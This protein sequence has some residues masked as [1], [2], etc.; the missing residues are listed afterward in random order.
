M[1]VS[2]ALSSCGEDPEKARK[3]YEA[4]LF[5]GKKKEHVKALKEFKKASKYDPSR[6]EY[7]FNVA[8]SSTYIDSSSEEALDIYESIIDSVAEIKDERRKVSLESGSY[9]G[10]ASI[11][12]VREDKEKAIFYLKKTILSASSLEVIHNF[13]SGDPDFYVF[14]E[15]PEFKR[16]LEWVS[17]KNHNH[18]KTAEIKNIVREELK[19]MDN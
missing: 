17:I 1:L 2:F 3:H 6:L 14:K 5:Y 18:I 16:I 10:I 15:E 9:Y 13:L 11:Y 4:G 7:L 19:G 8:V 12:A